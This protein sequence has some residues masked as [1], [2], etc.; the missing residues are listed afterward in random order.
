LKSWFSRR[1]FC[2]PGKIETLRG[3]PP[4]YVPLVKLVV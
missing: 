1:S 2:T 3:R 4:V